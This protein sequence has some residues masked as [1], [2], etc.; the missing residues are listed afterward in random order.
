[1]EFTDGIEKLFKIRECFEKNSK[2]QLQSRALLYTIVRA[3]FIYGQSSRKAVTQNYRA[4][5]MAASCRINEIGISTYY[6]GMLQCVF[7]L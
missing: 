6:G 7:F 4:C 3:N 1:M 2:K 5:E